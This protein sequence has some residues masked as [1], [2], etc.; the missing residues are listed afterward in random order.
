MLYYLIILLQRYVISA[1]WTKKLWIMLAN[2]I[3][4]R[5]ICAIH[6]LV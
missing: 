1:G 6:G 3:V 5:A 2:V 4:I